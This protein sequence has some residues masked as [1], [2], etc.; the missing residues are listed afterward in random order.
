MGEAD[1]LIAAASVL[2]GFLIVWIQRLAELWD[3]YSEQQKITSITIFGGFIWL[4]ACIITL[5]RSVTISFEYIRSGREE[6]FVTAY[7]LFFVALIGTTIYIFMGTSSYIRQVF[8][9][10]PGAVLAKKA[11]KFLFVIFFLFLVAYTIVVVFKP[12]LIN[13]LMDN[14]RRSIPMLS[15]LCI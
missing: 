6:A 9:G 2:A 11:P 8:F 13:G 15:E 1:A 7:N 12:Q 14:V 4:A 3:K 5:L 10:E